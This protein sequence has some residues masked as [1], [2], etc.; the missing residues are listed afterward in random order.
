M[1]VTVVGDAWVDRVTRWTGLVLLGRPGCVC[2]WDDRPAAGG[3]AAV[4]DATAGGADHG[5]L[6][7]A[8]HGGQGGLSNHAP[9]RIL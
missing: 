7:A 9:G 4:Q 8:L 3:P 2:R 1:L 6:L 5:M